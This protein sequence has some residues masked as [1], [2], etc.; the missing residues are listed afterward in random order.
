LQAIVIGYEVSTRI[1]EVVQPSHYAFF[2]TTGTV[3]VFGAAAACSSLLGLNAEQSMHAMATACTFASGLQQAFRSDSMTKPMHAGHAAEVGLNAA[4]CALVGITGTPDILEGPA[5]FGAAMSKDPRWQDVLKG[6]GEVFNITQMTFKNHGCCGHTF[7]AIDGAQYLMRTHK[8][9][10]SQIRAITLQVYR[11]SAEVCA[12][13]H[14]K[15]A[16]EAKFSLTHTVACGILFGAVREKRFLQ[17]NWVI[18]RFKRL[19][20]KSFTTLTQKLPV[21][22]RKCAV[23]KYALRWYLEKLLS[24]INTHAMAIPMIH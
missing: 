13:R 3:G 19:K 17:S 1:A 5:G 18:R 24:I 21:C 14:P 9:D 10:A 8:V 6:L 20:I 2:H 7:P 4:Y 16:F 12:Y 22:F 11:A 15:T 23:Q